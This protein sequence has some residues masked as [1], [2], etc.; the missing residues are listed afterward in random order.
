MNRVED[1]ILGGWKISFFYTYES[2]QPFT[3]QCP[4][5]TTADFG[6]AANVVAG[7]N[8]YSGPHNYH[9]WLNPSAFANPASAT[10]IGQADLS[11]LGGGVQQARGPHFS[12]LDSAIL[13][14]FKFTE[15]MKLQFRA[16]AFNLFNFVDLN[17]PSGALNSASFG[18]VTGAAN[19]RQMSLSLML[20]F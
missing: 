10:A 8:L 9:Q 18:K 13:K 14:D 11:P 19:P 7:Q 20:K 15:S 6:C 5:A 17:A 2:G 3:V 16:E 12:N 1:A 4:T